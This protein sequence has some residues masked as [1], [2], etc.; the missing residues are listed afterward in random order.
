MDGKVM[1]FLRTSSVARA[2]V[3]AHLR[4][5]G[6][7]LVLVHPVAPLP[8]AFEGLFHH[9]L[10]ADTCDVAELLPALADFLSASRLR[11]DAIVSLDEYA[12][13][14]AAVVATHF[15]LRPLPL[16]PAALQENNLKANFRLFCQRRRLAVPRGPVVL[17]QPPW[18]RACA[19]PGGG[20]AWERLLSA[21]AAA[22]GDLAFP[23]V[24][25]P[26]PGAGSLLVRRCDTVEAVAAHALTM[27]AQFDHHPDMKHFRALTQPVAAGSRPP[28]PAEAEMAE[29][30]GR[31]DSAMT[32]A[33]TYGTLVIVEEYVDGHEVDIDAVVEHGEVIF[34]AISDNFPTA[35]PYFAETG[36]L[37]PSALPAAAQR[38][39]RDLFLDYVRAQ[40]ACLHGVL[41]F[42]AKYDPQR[43][44]AYLIE[45]NCRLGSAE[46]NTMLKTAYNGLEL[47]ECFARC[48]LGLPVR[49]YVAHVLATRGDRELLADTAAVAAALGGSGDGFYA[50]GRYA[51]SVNLYPAREGVLTRLQLPTTAPRLRADLGGDVPLVGYSVSA[52][53]GDH[54]CPPPKRMYL[55]CWMVTEG[56]SVTEAVTRI[57]Y[58]TEHFVQQVGAEEE[59]Q[60]MAQL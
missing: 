14:T 59:Q 54:V 49:P 34:C 23:V 3:Y 11:P 51:A 24:L 22:L 53:V 18:W 35:P 26:S 30:Q 9:H 43:K 12:V 6:L 28:S 41:H 2:P 19:A 48:A 52:M 60:G 32:L 10:Q 27:W 21:V 31:W 17:E 56:G 16:P 40:G 46:T 55:L 8:P 4:R 58:L 7:T 38:S 1:V 37:C 47:G 13:Y 25:K 29:G 36:G 50:A 57:Q 15:G 20:E 33:T 39:L 5:C 45:V 44:R 42:E